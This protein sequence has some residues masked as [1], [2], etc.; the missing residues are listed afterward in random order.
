MPVGGDPFGGSVA[1]GS[2]PRRKCCVGHVGERGE[3]VLPLVGEGDESA[4]EL[5]GAVEIEG[6][7]PLEGEGGQ[8]VSGGRRGLVGHG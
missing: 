6:D 7:G 3:R 8:V 5:E 4:G 1:V 2:G